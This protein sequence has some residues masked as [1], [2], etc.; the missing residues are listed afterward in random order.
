MKKILLGQKNRLKAAWKVDFG[1]YLEGDEE[2]KILLP[3]RY[4]PDDLEIGDEVDVFIYLDN[5]ER[6]IATT[7]EPKAM[8]GDFAFLEVAWV[9]EYGAFL[10]WGLM[11]DLFCPFREQK[12]RMVKGRSYI[13]HVHLDEES[14]RSRSRRYSA[15]KVYTKVCPCGSQRDVPFRSPG[16]HYACPGPSGIP[17]WPL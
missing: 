15:G 17:L 8:V 5:E 7:V 3:S 1:V 11:K 10:D 12:Q 14:F 9:N 6:R 4:V 16:E 2:G 13:V